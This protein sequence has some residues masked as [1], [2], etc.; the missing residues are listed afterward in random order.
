MEPFCRN[1]SLAVKF[2]FGKK[3][4]KKKKIQ[5]SQDI[6]PIQFF[7][8]FSKHKVWVFSLKLHLILQHHGIGI[9]KQKLLKAS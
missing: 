4:W 7:Q 1:V 3:K 8:S 2:H 6:L 9:K 5:P